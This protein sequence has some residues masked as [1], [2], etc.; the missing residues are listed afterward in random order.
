MN[1][2]AKVIFYKDLMELEVEMETAV[3]FYEPYYR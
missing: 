1:T 2:K 3:E